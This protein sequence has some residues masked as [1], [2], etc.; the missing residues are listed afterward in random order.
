MPPSC[1]DEDLMRIGLPYSGR[2]ASLCS[3]LVHAANRD[4]FDYITQRRR[5]SK[6]VRMIETRIAALQGKNTRTREEI[7][8]TTIPRKDD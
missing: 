6:A 1:V 4:A 8:E 5:L 2:D 3:T 7:R